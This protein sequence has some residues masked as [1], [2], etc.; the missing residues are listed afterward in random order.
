[1][2]SPEPMNKSLSR[3]TLLG[4]AGAGFGMLALRSLLAE[5]ARADQALTAPAQAEPSQPDE[6]AELLQPR[7][8][9]H[10]ARAK[11]CIFVFLAGGPSQ[12]DTFDPKPCLTRDNGKPLPFARPKLELS[13][14]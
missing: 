9:H 2:H 1:M 14:T 12:I 3:R 13:K 8:T 6:T 11:R 7:R 4:T 10:P 5:E